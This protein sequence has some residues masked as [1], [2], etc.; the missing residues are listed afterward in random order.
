MKHKGYVELPVN[1]ALLATFK[2]ALENNKKAFKRLKRLY[3]LAAHKMLA[4]EMACW[5]T[6]WRRF[7][8]RLSKLPCYAP[9]QMPTIE[10]LTALLDDK[11]YRG[12]LYPILNTIPE[13]GGRFMDM[14]FWN[15]WHDH[16]IQ[17][18]KQF[19]EFLIE[20]IDSMQAQDAPTI[21]TCSTWTY[22]TLIGW[23][24]ADANNYFC[25]EPVMLHRFGCKLED[26]DLDTEPVM[27]TQT[28]V[29]K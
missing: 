3:C 14:S 13:P 16:Y 20:S 12:P 1:A 4:I 10:E 28:G 7:M 22:Q 5:N 25:I 19:R 29:A 15:L 17:T 6:R 26:F 9:L 18:G 24:Q 11:H 2:L 23:S 21:L 8:Y 27:A